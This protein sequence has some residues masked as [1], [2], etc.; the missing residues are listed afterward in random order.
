M[1]SRPVRQ[2]LPNS[3]IIAD[4]SRRKSAERELPGAPEV[5]GSRHQGQG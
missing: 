5:K 2:R 1:N 3:R 4:N